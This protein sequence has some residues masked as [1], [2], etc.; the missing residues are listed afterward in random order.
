MPVVARVL[1]FAF[2]FFSYIFSWPK[3]LHI[4]ICFTIVKWLVDS[5][6][7]GNRMTWNFLVLKYDLDYRNE[8]GWLI[9]KCKFTLMDRK[10]LVVLA[11]KRMTFSFKLSNQVLETYFHSHLGVFS[12]YNKCD[13]ND[14]FLYLWKLYTGQIYYR[15]LS[16]FPLYPSCFTFIVTKNNSLYRVNKSELYFLISLVFKSSR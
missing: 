6:L 14:L 2:V 4:D 5:K 15:K 13:I 10:N 8:G 1:A 9:K 7:S 16:F 3:I 12:C 11:R